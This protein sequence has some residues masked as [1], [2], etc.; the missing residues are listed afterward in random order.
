MVRTVIQIYLENQSVWQ[1]QLGPRHETATKQYLPVTLKLPFKNCP[2]VLL[3]LLNKPVHYYFNSI[4]VFQF[5]PL[6]VF[7]SLGPSPWGWGEEGNPK[8]PKT[9]SGKEYPNIYFSYFQNNWFCISIVLSIHWFRILLFSASFLT[10]IFLVVAR[11]FSS[12]YIF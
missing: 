8:T 6:W 3:F 1:Y 9:P 2:I 11:K 5:F 10:L 7:W 12:L 4:T